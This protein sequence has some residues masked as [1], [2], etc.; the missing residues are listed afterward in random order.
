MLS[1]TDPGFKF[2]KTY[3]LRSEQRWGQFDQTLAGDR[4]TGKEEGW[5]PLES[6]VEGKKQ[7]SLVK[8]CGCT[9]YI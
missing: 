6:Q 5:R 2:Y 8:Q 3:Y 9:T 4:N 1:F 7:F